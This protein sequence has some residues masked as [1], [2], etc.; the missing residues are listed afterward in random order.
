MKRLSAILIFSSLVLISGPG[1]SQDGWFPQTSNT[2]NYLQGVSFW[3][4]SNG[5]AFGFGGTILWTTNGGTTWSPVSGP[6]QSAFYSAFMTGPD[7]AT[8]V[9]SGGTI[10]RTT[11]RGMTWVAQPI[12]RTEEIR[13]IVYTDPLTAL[14]VGDNGLI[15]KTTSGGTTWATRNSGTTDNLYGLSF[16]PSGIGYAVGGFT[17]STIVRTTDGGETWQ[18]LPAGTSTILLAVSTVDGNTATAVGAAGT[19]L[20]TTDGGTTWTQQ[21]TGNSATLKGVNCIDANIAFLSGDGVFK[22]TDGGANWTPEHGT[23]TLQGGTIHMVDQYVGN[24]VGANGSILRTNSGGMYG[25]TRQPSGTHFT[26][27]GVSFGNANTGTAVGDSGTILRTIDGGASWFPQ[28]AGTYQHLRSV[29]FV[30]EEIGTVVGDTG[31]ILKTT[32]GG[33]HWVSQNSGTSSSLYSVCLVNESIGYAGGRQVGLKTTD[34]GVGWVPQSFRAPDNC[35]IRFFDADHGVA[36]MSPALGQAGARWT[37]D[38]GQN[39]AASSFQ[40]TG[41]RPQGVA[42]LSA[43]RVVAV[44]RGVARSSDGGVTWSDSI[45]NSGAL[46]DV[47]FSDETTGTAVGYAIFRTIDGGLSW[48]RQYDPLTARLYG[49]SQISSSTAVAVGDTGIIYRTASG[50]V[51]TGVKV[52]HPQIPEVHLLD[53]NYPNPFNPATTI[54]FTLP[55]SGFVRLVIYNVLGQQVTT[56]LASELSAGLHTVRW[57]AGHVPSGVYFCRLEVGHFVETRKLIVLR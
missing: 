35:A 23:S 13:S 42:M 18:P 2:T 50:G 56:L 25:W 46:Y 28:Q 27:W 19:I 38:G 24:A 37:T 17:S 29:S 33:S 43:T 32:D 39:W 36:A 51:F 44:G 8:V 26:L 9:G 15:M 34:G 1:F 11:N 22:T 45:N 5:V 49:V 4:V 12:G 7:E 47:S 3:D 20:R 14:V 31:T 48:T 55:Q 10:I 16:A 53:Q 52:A 41:F 40:P 30:S 54:R 21:Y 57:E 6:G